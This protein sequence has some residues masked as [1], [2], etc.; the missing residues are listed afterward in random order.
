MSKIIQ[1]FKALLLTIIFTIIFKILDSG[2]EINNVVSSL[3]QPIIFALS[4]TI[5]ILQTK[6]REFILFIAFV[7][8]SV[9]VIM[10]LA[11]RLD[12]SNFIGSLGF[13]ILIIV[14]SSS[15]S[16]MIKI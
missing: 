16:K 3:I 11:N 14:I 13:G 5:C 7:L 12:F 6:Y 15:L 4:A 10:Y 2:L 8:L 9:M 1:I